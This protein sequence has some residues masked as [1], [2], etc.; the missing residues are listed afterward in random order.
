[1]DQ[2]RPRQSKKLAKEGDVGTPPPNPPW[3]AE[4]S[5]ELRGWGLGLLFEILSL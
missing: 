4:L 2:W 5:T 3:G 1:M